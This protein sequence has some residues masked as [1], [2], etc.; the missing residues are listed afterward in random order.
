MTAPT[1]LAAAA[2]ADTTRMSLLMDLNGEDGPDSFSD[3]HSVDSDSSTNRRTHTDDDIGARRMN[4][5]VAADQDSEVAVAGPVHT[6]ASEEDE[7]CLTTQR[8][9]VGEEDDEDEEEDV[10]DTAYEEDGADSDDWLFGDTRYPASNSSN[11]ISESGDNVSNM[12]TAD[13]EQFD[14]FR[15]LNA[16]F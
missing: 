4:T 6:E 13:D 2:A 16:S 11:S 10:E 7:R 12:M 1:P 14:F 5:A 8:L 3:G 9:T 15:E